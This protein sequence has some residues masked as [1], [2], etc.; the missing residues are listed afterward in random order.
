LL[1]TQ[2][3]LTVYTRTYT[4]CTKKVATIPNYHPA[5]LNRI[6]AYQRE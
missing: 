6:K 4:R 1:P 2:F 5:V 3:V